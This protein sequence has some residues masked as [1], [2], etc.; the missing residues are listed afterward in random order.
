MS[1]GNKHKGQE[2]VH[3][4][5]MSVYKHRKTSDQPTFIIPA[6]FRQFFIF[7]KMNKNTFLSKEV[8]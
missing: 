4:G 3:I 7:Q 5:L 8:A 2:T 1:A 6:A